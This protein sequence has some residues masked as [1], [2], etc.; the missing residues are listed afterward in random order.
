[1]RRIPV[2]PRSA[3]ALLLAMST[4]AG[5]GVGAAPA[6]AAPQQP[7]RLG[8][9]TASAYT[10][11]QAEAYDDQSGTQTEPTTDVG[12]GFDVGYITP[13]DWIAFD[14]DF[15]PSSPASVM[16]R[17][18]SGSVVSGTIRWRLDSPTGPAFA[19][20]LS[21]PTGGWQTWKTAPADITL[22]TTGVHRVYLTFTGA[23]GVD[24]VNVNWFQFNP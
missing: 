4:V 19:T 10:L 21:F 13:G 15:G 1:M 20:T 18:A 24:L 22:P 14:L 17:I 8:S 3:A 6:A 23:S 5:A 12:G 16:A 7:D 11:T 2:L 9:L